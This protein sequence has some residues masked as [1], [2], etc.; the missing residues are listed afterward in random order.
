MQEAKS[1]DGNATDE[2]L[3]LVSLKPEERWNLGNDDENNE[4]MKV[5]V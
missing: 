2:L 4:S 3:L 1:K 5:C